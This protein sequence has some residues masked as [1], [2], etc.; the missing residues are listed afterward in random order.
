MQFSVKILSNDKFCGQNS[1]VG[2]S[3]PLPS[4]KSWIRHCIV[5]HLRDPKINFFRLATNFTYDFMISRGGGG[6]KPIIWQDFFKNCMKIN[7]TRLHS[8]RMRTARLLPVS[9][10]MDCPG[11]YLW[12]VGYLHGGC[13]CPGGMYLPIGCICLWSLGGTCLGGVPARGG[14][15][16]QV[17]PPAPLWFNLFFLLKVLSHRENLGSRQREIILERS[18]RY[19]SN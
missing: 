3:T 18:G 9:P 10:S 11:G 5:L 1:G 2:A 15:P 16:G 4:R 12:G 19:R 17:L 13:T 6:A 8:I 7:K 14:V